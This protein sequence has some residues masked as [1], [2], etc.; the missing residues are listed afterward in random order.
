MKNAMLPSWVLDIP[1]SA[2][3]HAYPSFLN[4]LVR[5]GVLALLASLC[6]GLSA[7][8]Q[9]ALEWTWMGGSSSHN[10]A[11]V[12]GTLGTPAAGNIP[13]GRYVASSWTDSSGHLWL[14]G[15]YGYD[16][17]DVSG[18]L[19][20][21]WEFD[22]S[23][24]QW[25]WMSGSKSANHPGVFGTLGT[26]AAGS[27][28][29]GRYGASNWTD[30]SGHFWLF[31]G[32]GY[33]AHG[34]Y[35]Y[36]SDLWEFNPSTNQWA[37]MC[38]SSS[39]NQPGVYGTFGTSAAGNTPGGREGAAAWTDRNGHLWL[40][41][42]L[43][44]DA[45]G[46][47]G[48]LNDL[49]EFNPS[50]NQWAWRGGSLGDNSSAGM[51]GTLGTPAAGNTPGSRSSALSWTDSSGHFWLFGG[52]GLG[53]GSSA[54]AAYGSLND[55]WEF[56]PSTNQ[57]AWMGGSSSINQ[58][59]V[60]GTLGTPAAGNIPG[61][62]REASSWTDNSGH[63]WLFGGVSFDGDYGFLN[64]LWEFNPSTNKWAWMGGSS[65][66]NQ[67]SVYGALGTPAAGN[68]PGGRQDASSWTDS[69]GHLWLFGGAGFDG[70]ASYGALNDLWIYQLAPAA[71]PPVALLS[72]TSLS[73]G[74]LNVGGSSASQSVTLSNT[75]GS[76][77][78]VTGI[79]VTGANAAS[80][81][82]ANSC[83][84]TLAVGA[85]CS[86][87]GH[88]AP[89]TTGALTAAITITDNAA[90]SPQSIALSGTGVN[91]TTVS[92]SS[93]SLSFG[94][95]GVGGASASQQVTLTNTGAS[96]LFLTSIHVT[97]AAASSFVFANS[98]VSTLAAGANCS[99]HGHFAPTAGGALT[100]AVTITGSATGSPQT[101]A[102]SGTGVEPAVSLSAASLGF[103]AQQIGTP[104]ATQQLTLTNTGGA[105]LALAGIA[106]TGADASSFVFTNT[107]GPS[108]GAGSNCTIRGHFAPTAAGAL[109]AAITITDDAPGSPQSVALSGTGAANPTTISLSSTSL[110]FGTVR[111]GSA[112]AS[113]QV[114]L[115][116]TGAST[117]SITGV[118]V[119]GANA[120]SFV[121]GNNCGSSLPAGSS[122]SI[123]GHFAPTATG[124]LTAA[125]AIIDSASGSPQSIALSGTGQ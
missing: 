102:L 20:D 106:V 42:G 29:G 21:L 19:N 99:I 37:W 56:N 57:W 74:S 10:Q 51:Y 123:H 118:S 112:S 75:G 24:S 15:G 2:S 115:T 119:T 30:S 17:N 39:A 67:P 53:Y 111:V 49:W 117:L 44:N 125:I 28:P 36:L 66:L 72:S 9:E 92:L 31:G 7:A 34:N 85:S 120:S 86:I 5:P 48:Y 77:L 69:S 23:T 59:G 22:P 13:G 113:Q 46:G 109:S 122:C 61:N 52:N 79:S 114:T 64:D 11:S 58:P 32:D 54:Q 27:V 12:Y 124:H 16:A 71:L 90:G 1:S 76:P 95:V 107:C 89:Q 88:F 47:L 101:I 4:R 26:P 78:S 93:T 73:F 35:G 63:L 8:A 108:L 33:D 62:R 83:G 41:G 14:F 103:S 82:F 70:N 94:S 80:F 43:G 55:L 116:N 50:T 38:G 25:A 87:H 68:I 3:R 110:S 60:Y 96:T 98:C 6:F 65:S 45:Y 81:A 100:A 105:H 91:P 18:D 104:S 84:S 121:F 97:G 40:F